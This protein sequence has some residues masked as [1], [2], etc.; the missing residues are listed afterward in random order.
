[1]NN[2]QNQTN[3]YEIKNPQTNQ[4]PQTKGPEMNERDFLN[5]ILATEKYITD[6]FNVF[7]REA[8]NHTLYQTAITILNESHVAARTLFNLMF[9][10][11][12]Y[13]LTAAQQQDIQKASQQFQNY[14]SQQPY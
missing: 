4:L 9:K 8:S 11:G 1:M 7:V 14:Q 12:W 10:K 2:N 5:D 3:P 6:N 13:A